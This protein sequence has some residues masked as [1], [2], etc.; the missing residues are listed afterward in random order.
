MKHHPQSPNERSGQH[1]H[2]DADDIRQALNQLLDLLAAGLARRL[3]RE[4]R[5]DDADSLGRRQADKD[6]RRSPDP[7]PNDKET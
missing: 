1:H 2:D 7:R 6:T 5:S 3:L 4:G